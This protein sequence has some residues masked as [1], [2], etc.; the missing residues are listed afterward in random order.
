MKLRIS[1]EEFIH[2]KLA[3]EAE[4]EGDMEGEEQD[5][6]EAEAKSEEEGTDKRSAPAGWL[7]QLSKSLRKL[8]DRDG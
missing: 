7:S 2:A 4:A 1:V 8:W 3:Q 5:R 6:V